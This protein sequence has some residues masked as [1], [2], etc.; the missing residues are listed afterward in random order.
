MKKWNTKD[1]ER[2]RERDTVLQEKRGQEDKII[3]QMLNEM[4]VVERLDWFK[5]IYLKFR[6]SFGLELEKVKDTE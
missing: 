5:E 1:P 3:G 6:G 2:E 4:E